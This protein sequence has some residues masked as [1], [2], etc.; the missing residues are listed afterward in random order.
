MTVEEHRKQLDLKFNAVFKQFED[1][2]VGETDES[3]QAVDNTLEN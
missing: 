3:L 2:V 1:L